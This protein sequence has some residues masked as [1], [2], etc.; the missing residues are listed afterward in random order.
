MKKAS[1]GYVSDVRPRKAKKEFDPY[2]R[3]KRNRK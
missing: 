3:V 1:L 2:R